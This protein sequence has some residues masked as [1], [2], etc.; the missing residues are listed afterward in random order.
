M[1]NK[2]SK[3]EE[4][5]SLARELAQEGIVLLANE[6][7]I[8]PLKE[9]KTVAL[10]GRVQNNTNIG[11]GG[12][13]FAQCDNPL[14]IRAELKAAGVSL[15]AGIDA[16]YEGIAG[17]EISADEARRQ[18]MAEMFASGIEGLVA[19][20]MIYE[21]FGKYNAPKEEPMV[22]AETLDA[23]AR[24]TDTAILVIGRD[25]GGEECDRRVQDDYYL[26]PSEEAL[27]EAAAARFANLIIVYNVNGAVDTGWMLRY[28]QIKAAL[29]MGTAGEQGAGALAD[30][31][32][33]KVSPSGKLTQTLAL[34]YEDYPTAEN[35]CYNKDDVS[36]IRTYADYGLS[37]E[38]NGSVGKDLSPVTLYQ[39]GIYV[40][41]R[42]FDTYLKDVMFPF[43]HGLSY[44][45]FDLKCISADLYEG[46]LC[47][48]V[49]VKNT[50]DTYSGKE[51]VQLYISALDGVLD[52]PLQELKAFA[53][54]DVLAPGQTETVVL[55]VPIQELASFDEEHM[56]YLIE[57][58]MYMVFIGTGSRDG[59]AVASL[60][61]EEDVVTREVTADIGPLACNAGKIEWMTGPDEEDLPEDLWDEEDE[62]GISADKDA[63]EEVDDA[64]ED[65]DDV[66]AIWD[67]EELPVLKVTAEDLCLCWESEPIYD[68]SVPAEKS[69]LRDVADGRVSMEAFINQMSFDELLVLCTGWGSGLPF[70]G[71]MAGDA[72]VSLK[73]PDGTD[74]GTC[75]REGAMQG[76]TSPAL[77]KYGIP[78]AVY[79][80]GPASVGMT[81]WPTD[82]VIAQTWN[83]ELMYQFGSACGWE[84][85]SQGVDSW[86][87]PGMDIMRN[88][89]CGRNFEYFSE[90]P[91]VTGVCAVEIT[92]GAME[93][94]HVTTCPKHFALN[95]Q[96]TYRRG[97]GKKN[98]DAADSIV[99]ARAAREIYLKPFEMVVTQAEP[100]TVMTSFNRINGTF[101]GGDH[102][103]CTEILRGEWGYDGVVVTDWGDMD[104]VVD[105][106]DA[107]A[108]GNDVVMPGGPPVM[109]QIR[110][111]Y[112]EGRVTL[113]DMKLAAAHLM[114]FVMNSAAMDNK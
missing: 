39:E 86:L 20:G 87:A 93:T 108:A 104:I 23:A 58:G 15:E 10:L 85:A 99:S 44:A 43:G 30:I 111:G 50:S 112:E 107:V 28:P 2:Y 9:G 47:V 103:L 74:I 113:E 12:S 24:V 26:I 59:F 97:S 54:T 6:D 48:T 92:K 81:A 65:E 49:S 96:E 63:A 5:L 33:G 90:D 21:I 40:G 14:Q 53:K 110:K 109:E 52:K 66:T 71:A 8:L 32:T 94:N 98:I 102:A 64:E 73:Y 91:Y 1:E 89:I 55:N 45:D 78:S 61:F 79:K 77:V 100:T 25:S 69:V 13:G 95:E 29:F 88:P 42:Y 56:C 76:Y 101:A 36:S 38:E 72:P 7:H 51:T 57:Q 67:G 46:S 35:F 60:L 82:M 106:A 83:T 27:L 16:F 75:D 68:F 114:N 84:A 31:L 37:A 17:Q 105:G 11:G 41:Y 62:D 70:G 19:S 4:R 22:P 18:Q 34:T 3:A 80:D